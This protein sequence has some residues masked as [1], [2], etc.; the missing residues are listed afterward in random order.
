MVRAATTVTTIGSYRSRCNKNVEAAMASFRHHKTYTWRLAKTG[1]YLVVA[2]GLAVLFETIL[3]ANVQS[4][5]NKQTTIQLLSEKT[6]DERGVHV[7]LDNE[8]LGSSEVHAQKGK[9]LTLRVVVGFNIDN[10]FFCRADERAPMVSIKTPW[11]IEMDDG[12]T[13]RHNRVAIPR[14]SA[15]TF[16]YFANGASAKRRVVQENHGIV[17]TVDIP[18]ASIPEALD[19]VSVPIQIQIAIF[20]TASCTMYHLNEVRHLDITLDEDPA[21]TK[22]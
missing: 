20:D 22:E 4:Q 2:C 16:L 18:L 17:T 21:Q 5:E 6:A 12:R 9:D 13:Y 14:R 8:Y 1:R 15:Y 3:V 10:P 11:T 7:L 19:Q